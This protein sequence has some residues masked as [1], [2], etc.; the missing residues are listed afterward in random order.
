MVRTL[1]SHLSDFAEP[2]AD[3]MRLHATGL[4]VD[5]HAIVAPDQLR[6]EMESLRGRLAATRQ[7]MNDYRSSSRGRDHVPEHAP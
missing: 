2:A 1:I 7:M 4:I 6:A 3:A 5:G